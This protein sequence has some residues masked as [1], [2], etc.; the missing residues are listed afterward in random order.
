[1]V[2]LPGRTPL[3]VS[4]RVGDAVSSVQVVYADGDSREAA[5]ANGYFLGWVLPEAGAPT[6]RTGFSPP[7]TL[8]A[9]DSAGDELGHLLVRGDGDIPP[10]PGQPAQAVACG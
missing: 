2:T 6:G 8:V 3:L 10:S 5:V 4:G 1:M 9:R 7:V